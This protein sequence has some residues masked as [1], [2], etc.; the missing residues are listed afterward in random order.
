MPK[1]LKYSGIIFDLDGTLVE[2]MLLYKEAF[3]HMIKQADIPM[4]SDE[5]W[6]MYWNNTHISKILKL[7]NLE[8]E[9]QRFR[10]IRDKY[11]M[12]LLRKKVEWFPDAKVLLDTL[13]IEIPKAILTGSW[14]KYVDAIETRLPISDYFETIVTCDDF[15]PKGKPDPCGLLIAAERLGVSPEKCVY[16][17]DQLFDIEAAHNAGMDGILIKRPVYTPEDVGSIE[18]V[19]QAL[20]ELERYIY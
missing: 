19:V 3:M 15:L 17:G 14:M 12:N 10:L 2:S 4:S 9:E 13:P 16:I 20:G 18:M 11:Y 6:E 7:N 8:N 5:F 1:Q